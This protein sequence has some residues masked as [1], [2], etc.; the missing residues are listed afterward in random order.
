MKFPFSLLVVAALFVSCYPTPIHVKA[1]HKVMNAYNKKMENEG[2]TLSGSGGAMMDDVKQITLHYDIG[3]KL[4]LEE[5]RI[6]FVKEAEDLLCSINQN[7]E[8][9]PYLHIYPFNS[10]NIYLTLSFC[11]P[12]GDFVDPP[13]IA[14]VAMDVERNQVCYLIIHERSNALTLVHAEPYEE[15]LRIYTETH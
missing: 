14:Y 9:R 7:L 4:T 12:S 6:L 3:L 13:F 11:K 15:A 2:F 8:I 5:A 1:A 10:Q